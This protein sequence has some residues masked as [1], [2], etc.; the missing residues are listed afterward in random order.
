M[1]QYVLLCAAALVAPADPAF[2]EAPAKAP[3]KPASSTVEGVT[4]T[5]TAPPVRTSIDRKSYSVTNDLQATTGS[6]SDALRNIPSVEVD[7]QGN[8]SLRG[9]QNV[10]IM[11][12][13]KPS[14][15]FRGEGKGQ[16]LQSLPADQIER[17]EV[18]TNPSAEFKPD[19]TGGIINLITKKSHKAGVTGSVKANVGTGS[20]ANGGVSAAYAGKAFTLSGDAS[21]RR[22]SFRQVFEENRSTFDPGLAGFRDLSEVTHSHGKVDILTGRAGADFDP[23]AK[24]HAGGQLRYQGVDFH[25]HLAEA[26]DKTLPD[27]TP[28]TAYTRTLVTSQRRR[29]VEGTLNYSYKFGDDHEFSAS[30]TEE[31]QTDHRHRP[32]L[33]RFSVPALPDAFEE[34]KADNTF[35]RTEAKVAYSTPLPGAA[36]LKLGYEFDEDDNDY[37]NSGARGS[38]AALAAPDPTQINLFNFDQKIHAAFATYERPLG[39]LTI[40]A[41]LRVESVRIDLDQVTQAITRSND[42]DR[43][44]PS[45]HLAYKLDDAQQLTASASR[46]VQRPQ[47][48]D[49]NPFRQYLDPQNFR[50]GNP[51]L[52]PQQTDSY[53]LGYQYRKNG[54]ILLAT[55]YYRDGKDAVNDVTQDLGNGVFLTTRANIGSF[56]TA[57]LE[58]VANGRLPH[59]LS[60]N[61]SSNLLWNQIDGAGLGFG[62]SDRSGYSLSGRASLSWQATGKD[63]FQ[64]S[65]FVNGRRLTPQGYARPFGM[66]NLGYRH[67]LDD[68]LSFVM[69][70]QDAAKTFH[71]HRVIDTPTLKDVVR[72]HGNF[73]G[74]FVGFSYTFGGGKAKDPGFDFGQGGG[75]PGP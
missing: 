22:D 59:R 24:T 35:W 31:W 57:G 30:A 3:A 6:I 53:E 49:F 73:R 26:V 71:D 23:D 36:K 69:T 55:A 39:K 8:V 18:I 44:Y 32:A 52:K 56:R 20:R 12:D 75:P 61:V 34:T 19:G 14:G 38:S 74:V 64:V 16:A 29:D 51:G 40:L 37:G 33:A 47:P 28:D 45:L 62:A 60:Y 13:G 70:V 7:L 27:G 46:R 1:R 4:V 48:F 17:V 58:L 54:T 15:M 43:A 65:G 68:Q 2:A 63:F 25:N 42:Y 67:K 72:V 50:S 9:D 41:G 11:I 10:T 5:G 21:Y 66:L